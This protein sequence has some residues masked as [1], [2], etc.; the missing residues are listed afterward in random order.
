[1]TDDGAF[2][3]ITARTTTTVGGAIRAQGAQGRTAR[4]FGDLITGAILFRET[5]APSLRVQ[6]ILKGAEGGSL[7]A[8]SHPSGDTRGLVQSAPTTDVT[9]GRGATL[10]VM[11]SLPGGRLN[12]GIVAVPEQGGIS[13]A[14]MEYMQTSEQV[15]SMLAV[16]TVLDGDRAVSAGGFM[17]QLLPEVDREP[18]AIM[19]ER[20]D[21]F[22]TI[23]ST[24]EEPDFSPSMLLDRL[25]DGMPYT[26]L[27]D[28][29]VAFNCWCSHVRVLSALATLGRGDLESLVSDGEV[30]EITCD[31]CGKG[32]E[33]A[34]EQLRGLLEES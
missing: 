21:G 26:R 3:V 17:V 6:G 2:R 9:L 12:Q 31:Y 5:M 23:E 34:P 25:L 33:V 1:M 8:D 30:L 13:T 7:V 29:T 19:T 15:V 11:R 27:D 28:S 10:R 32:Y 18:L 16:A 4:Y 22:R 20:L 14:L 24:V